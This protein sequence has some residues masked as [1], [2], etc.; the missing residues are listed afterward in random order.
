MGLDMCMTADRYVGGWRHNEGTEEYALYKKMVS[1][2]GLYNI[3]TEGNPSLT[4]A[5]TVAYWRKA[6]QIH[7]WFVKEIQDGEDNCQKSYVSK[8]Y[9]KDLV[10]LCEEVL[11]DH[12]KAEELLPSSNGFFFGNTDYDEYYYA[13]LEDTIKQIKPLLTLEGYDFYYHAS[14]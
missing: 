10:C 14:W 4:I 5:F 6:N 9:L 2:F 8:E 1:D 12:T 13:D 7:N 11:A 3:V